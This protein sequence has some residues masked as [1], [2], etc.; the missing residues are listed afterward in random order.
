MS[1]GTVRGLITL[2]LMLAFI[3]LVLWA[4]SKRRKAD[5]EEM[6]QLPFQEYPPDKEQGSKTP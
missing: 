5:F 1:I 2:V 4:Y 6:A 3:G